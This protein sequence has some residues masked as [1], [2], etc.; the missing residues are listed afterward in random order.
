MLKK[1][2][3]ITDKGFLNSCIFYFN[4]AWRYLKSKAAFL[5]TYMSSIVTALMKQ[6]YKKSEAE[7]VVK[8]ALDGMY[9]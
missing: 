2:I 8:K 9:V 5:T 7:T 6:G 4:K 3:P 1:K